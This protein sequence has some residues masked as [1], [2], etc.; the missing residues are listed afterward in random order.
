MAP[1]SNKFLDDLQEKQR[2]I[3]NKLQSIHS[4]WQI[5][6][7]SEMDYSVQREE[8]GKEIKVMAAALLALL[9]QDYAGQKADDIVTM[10]MEWNDM[11][12][13]KRDPA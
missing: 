12:S 3:Y 5:L 4:R 8:V 10:L 11:G 2:V 13:K 1:F 7:D 6:K 9:C